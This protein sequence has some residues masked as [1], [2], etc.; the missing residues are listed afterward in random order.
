MPLGLCI[1]LDFVF[2]CDS[3]FYSCF[4]CNPVVTVCYPIFCVC[5]SRALLVVESRPSVPELV[6]TTETIESLSQQD[7]LY[8]NM[9]NCA[10]N[11]RGKPEMSMLAEITAEAVALAEMQTQPVDLPTSVDSVEVETIQMTGH[12]VKN[13]AV[14]VATG[15]D[16]GLAG[17]P[18]QVDDCE[19]PVFEG[20]NP[21]CASDEPMERTNLRQ[22]TW[23]EAQGSRTEQYQNNDLLQQTTILCA[24]VESL[25][26]QM[27]YVQN[28]GKQMQD[29][30]AAESLRRHEDYRNMQKTMTAKMEEGFRSEQQA[31]QQAPSE[32]MKGLTDEENARQEEMKSLN[33]GSGST[34]CSGVGSS[35]TL[36]RPRL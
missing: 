12:I 10:E 22:L 28:L 23:S 8:K 5:G 15:E 24:T 30:F 17:C 21:G 6:K 13:M 35:G 33:I 19:N 3:V 27:Q 14:A 29:G 18:Q 32:M 2:F 11:R 9:E 16:G 1:N 7:S 31:R 20:R 36:A 34:A 26:K 25:R 4:S